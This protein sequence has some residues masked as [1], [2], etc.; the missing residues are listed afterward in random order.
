MLRRGFL[1][2]ASVAAAIA[3][4]RAQTAPAVAPPQ[5]AAPLVLHTPEARYEVVPNGTHVV[6]RVLPPAAP[7]AMTE[8]PAE[9]DVVMIRIGPEEEALT[10]RVI[11]TD[12]TAAEVR[13]N[14][15]ATTQPLDAL[16]TVA[17]DP[18]TGLATRDTLLHHRGDGGE[19]DIRALLGCCLTTHEP[20]ER[21]LY[22]A[23]AWTE[24]TQITRA[25]FP[26]APLALESRVGKTGF[27]FQ[28]YVA[29]RSAD[30]TV[31]AELMW[32]GNW[33]LE[34]DP[35]DH[36]ALIR[37]GIN[38]WEFRHRM[39]P[40]TSLALPQVLF[41][42]VEG[43]MNRATQRL[44]DWRRAR[45][46]DPDRPILVQ[47]NSWYRY[48]G[49]LRADVLLSV[50]PLVA[51]LGC[52]VFVIDAGWFRPDSGD[53]PGAWYDRTGDWRVSRRR[54][55]DGMQPIAD[56]CRQHGLRFGLW[57][58][59]EVI[60]TLSSIR[61]ERP[62]WLHHIDGKPPGAQERAIL[63][64]GVPDA[65]S[66]AFDRVT[67][68]LRLFAV[69]WMKWDFNADLFA[70][71]WAPGLPAD[72]TMQDPLI[73]HYHGLYRLQ[74]AIR[75]AFP[76]LT[77][78][79]CASGGGRMDGAILS[80][81]HLNWIS[82]QPGA[83]RKLAIHFGSQLA[84]PAVACNDWLVEWPAGNI[85]GY[86]A[87]PPDLMEA[88][89]LPFRL[90]VAM[91]GSF[92]IGAPVD[93]WSDT[94]ISVVAAHVALYRGELRDIIHHGDQY[95]LTRSPPPDGVGDWAAIWYVRKDGQGGVLF[96]FRL[97]GEAASEAFPLPGLLP[98]RDFHCRRFG[99]AG[100]DLLGRG[101]GRA[102]TVTLNRPYRSELCVVTAA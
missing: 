8:I 95:L 60:G 72:L 93:R 12:A 24:E 44:H 18:Q 90:R 20:V 19:I 61:E 10:W 25:P 56:A 78:E 50:I 9:V 54:F 40:G 77:L 94:E 97:A 45:R 39:R 68:V 91:L 74:D 69:D 79:M 32:S 6:C 98:D 38:P 73:A 22:L 37:G 75:A 27:G 65:W 63:N 76:D 88:G 71:G 96:A 85:A 11:D 13:I 64:L 52:E 21:V 80:R 81:A 46:P 83:L 35:T 102:V 30:A 16:V 31:L 34:V 17:V 57:F 53:T 86:D 3:P 1:T 55:P 51:R 49:D 28:P 26:K 100:G 43:G 87:L 33:R 101:S 89:D 48:F 58:E 47:F 62:E 2:G 42:R 23:G 84:H 7:A 29:L 82:D 99:E 66:Y 5:P 41:G 4:A 36:G 92:G 14:L 70:G 15:R 67:R 59:P